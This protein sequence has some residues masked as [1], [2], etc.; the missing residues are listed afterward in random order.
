MASAVEPDITALV[1]LPL[2][3]PL[4]SS[5]FLDPDFDPST[6][7]LERRHTPLDE[8]RS[9]VSTPLASSWSNFKLSRRVLA[10][11]GVDHNAKLTPFATLQLRAYL[12]TLRTSL[13]AVINEEYESFIGL[14]LGL[15]QAAVSNSLAT[16]RRPVLNIRNEVLLVKETL[17]EMRE[18]MEGVLEI[19][20]SV[21]EGKAVLRRLL[22]V[23]EA[24]EKVET[25]LM[26]GEGSIRATKGR[27]LDQ[28]VP[29]LE[30]VIAKYS[31]LDAA[32]SIRRR[33][34]S[35]E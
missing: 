31:L 30:T 21:R 29:I 24:V 32:L 11:Q 12:A 4:A 5:L 25:L 20:K 9:E 33:K 23:E 8:L 6:F 34:G 15:R 16:I 3:P 27:D 18:E 19:R 22:E 13:V 35:K 7:L 28:L 1:E 14:S 10:G 26:I 2:P 17:E